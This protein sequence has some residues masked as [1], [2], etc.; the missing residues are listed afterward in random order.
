M[1]PPQTLE[2]E[3]QFTKEI[4]DMLAQA[5]IGDPEENY[6]CGDLNTQLV[7]AA[8]DGFLQ[9]VR[10]LLNQGADIHTQDDAPLR[11]AIIY[12]HA[13]IVQ[14]LINSE[15]D[16]NA[17][18]GAP[19]RHAV[20]HGRTEIY[21]MLVCAGANE[22]TATFSQRAYIKTLGFA[23]AVKARALDFIRDF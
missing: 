8:G 23:A 11:H 3:Q 17:H 15:A 21:E 22:A 14:L 13:K 19:L 10:G 9:T 7:H 6:L 4:N 12:G 2:E 16:V 1:A 18:F 5:G 20:Y